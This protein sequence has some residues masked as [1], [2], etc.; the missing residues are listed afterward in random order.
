MNSYD[1][2]CGADIGAKDRNDVDALWVT[3]GNG[4]CEV[5]SLLLQRGGANIKQSCII[6][7]GITPVMIA[8]LERSSFCA[9]ALVV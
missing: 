9:R 8:R 3:V 6:S 2:C 7:K 5:T 1:R 4:D